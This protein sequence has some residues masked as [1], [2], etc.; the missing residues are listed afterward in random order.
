MQ[1]CKASQSRYVDHHTVPRVRSVTSPHP[2]SC[3]LAK[4]QGMNLNQ[5]TIADPF[6]DL[7]VAQLRRRT[8]AKWK[9]YPDDVLPL[10]VAEMDAVIA[11]PIA[12]AVQEAL[13]IGDTGY[14]Y[15]PAY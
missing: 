6:A 4:K 8:S 9:V 2:G 3:R 12:A 7:D 11:R 14:P 10:W 1:H 5:L 13:E 15:G